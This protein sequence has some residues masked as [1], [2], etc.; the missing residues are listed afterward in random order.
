MAR[1]VTA[2][3]SASR[4][5]WA[6]SISMTSPVIKVESTS[7]QISRLERRCRPSRSMAMSI[8]C[9]MANSASALR[10]GMPAPGLGSGSDTFSS[11]PVTG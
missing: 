3:T 1:S 4:P 2:A 9:A 11:R 8:C 7:K 5:A 6:A 10:T